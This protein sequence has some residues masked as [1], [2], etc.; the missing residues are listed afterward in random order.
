MPVLPIRRRAVRLAATLVTAAV[1]TAPLARAPLHA[2]QPEGTTSRADSVRRA[3]AASADSATRVLPVV[4]VTATRSTRAVTDAAAAVTVLAPGDY[5]YRSGVGIDA[6][7]ALVPGVLAQSRAGGTDVRLT[8]RGF[9]ARG[10]GDRSNAGTSRGVR[11]LVDGI[12][13]TEP[14]GRTSF[15][16]LDLS[17]AQGIDVVRSNAS[18]LWGNAAG[19]VINVSTVPEADGPFATA[20]SVAGSYGLVRGV[21]QGGTPLGAAGRLWGTATRTTGDGWRAHSDSRRTLVGAGLIAPVGESRATTIGVHLAAADNFFR[22][23]GPLSPAQAAADPRQANATYAARDER[24]HNRVGRLGV[25]VEHRF[26]A[27]DSTPGRERTLSGLLFV[28]PKYLQRSERGTFRDFTR[29]HVGASTM[30]RA[31]RRPLA[32]GLAHEL[33][34]GGDAALQDGA[35]LFYSLSPDNERG[36]ELRDDK[37]EGATNLGVFVQDELE[38]GERLLL[39]LGAR[40]DA[41]RY[42]YRSHTDPTL[43]AV[44]TFSRTSPKVS[45]LWRLGPGQSVYASVGG[46][47]EAPAGNETDPAGTYGQDTVTAI[48]PLLEP[49]RS[50]TYELGTKRVA[51]PRGAGPLLS[52]AYDVALYLTDVHNE[53]VPYRG[54]RFYFT[55][56]RARRAGLEVGGTAA[57]RGG[58][59]ARVAGTLSRNRYEDYTVDSVHYGRPGQIADYSGNRVVGVPDWFWSSQLAWAPRAAARLGLEARLGA[60]GTSRYWADDANT[61]R[62][63]EFTTASATLA[64]GAAPGHESA[65]AFGGLGV[66]AFVTVENLF[67]RRYIGSAFLNPDVVDGAPLVYEPAPPR[68]VVV[69]LS[70][71]AR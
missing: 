71:H 53:I 3:R 5:A 20:Q 60:Q 37:A 41:I 39:T 61:I 59:T 47:V 56:G 16:N 9:G 68:T 43:N 17:I 1:V 24:R 52:A 26:D 57:L 27:A 8:V 69:S 2:Q 30:Y 25:T 44:K 65:L 23:P 67:D 28:N 45:A 64:L 33:S 7:L 12:P 32:G 38:V 49:I 62:V 22:V 54:G 40:H 66:R 6:A 34:L 19:G 51:V 58:V 36:T 15:D 14:D 21:V 18:A 63:P 48:N 42:D 31:G 35:I 10:A 11:V 29:Y 13:E 55:A 70:L 4:T 50:T 46:G